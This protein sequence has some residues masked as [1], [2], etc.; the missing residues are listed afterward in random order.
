MTLLKPA[1][2]LCGKKSATVSSNLEF[3]GYAKS[4]NNLMAATTPLHHRR[5]HCPSY[6]LKSKVIDLLR[7]RN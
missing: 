4:M 3:A 1:T 7:V 2:D 5:Q 6:T